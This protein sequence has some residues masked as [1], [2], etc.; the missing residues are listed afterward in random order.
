MKNRPWS[1]ALAALAFATAPALGVESAKP[2]APQATTS[3]P[4]SKACPDLAARLTL[5]TSLVNGRGHV[6]LHA[7]VCNVGNRDFVAPP[8]PAMRAEYQVTTWHPPKTPA[9]EGNTAVFAGPIPIAT[10]I[11]VGQCISYEQSYSFDG[12]IRW[13]APAVRPHLAADERLAQKQFSFALVYPPSGYVY[14]PADDCSP[15]NNSAS[16]AVSYTDKK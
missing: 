4:G 15:A 7:K 11:P 1:A 12:V 14:K 10:Q 8:Q 3:G 16:V 2:A 13:L 9:Q 5:E 6:A